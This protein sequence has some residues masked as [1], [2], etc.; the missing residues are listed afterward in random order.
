M[1][2]M[3]Y[4][5]AG[6]NQSLQVKLTGEYLK[7]ISSNYDFMPPFHN[8]PFKKGGLP[9]NEMAQ[10]AMVPISLVMTHLSKKCKLHFWE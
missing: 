2:H 8:F 9:I 5:T 7:A 1:Q 4:I 3:Q 10:Y 6:S